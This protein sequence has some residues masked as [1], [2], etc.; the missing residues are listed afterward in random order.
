MVFKKGHLSWCKG[1]TKETDKRVRKMANSKRGSKHS[2]E[3][4][5]KMR[6]AHRDKTPTEEHKQNISQAKKGIHTSPAT[7]FKK[8]HQQSK[9]ARQKMSLV[10]K[11]RIANDPEYVKRLIEN[12]KTA[13]NHPNK[14]EIRLLKILQDINP[15]WRY[16]GDGSLVIDG[17]CPDFTDDNGHLI[18]LFGAYWHEPDEE[19]ERVGFFNERGFDCRV[20]WDHEI[21]QMGPDHAV[22]GELGVWHEGPKPRR[23]R[24]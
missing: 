12:L 9:T 5:R 19:Q 4:K 2:E 22:V 10:K 24:R 1:L 7:E 15:A 16:V 6:L 20:I 18:E 11:R 3:T 8:G 13:Y 23:C 21:S 14:A 17:K